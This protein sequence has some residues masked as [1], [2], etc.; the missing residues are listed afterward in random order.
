MFHRVEAYF[1]MGIL[2]EELEL[3][4]KIVAIKKGKKSDFDILKNF[5]IN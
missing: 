5:Q 2:M 4:D 3:M 1:S